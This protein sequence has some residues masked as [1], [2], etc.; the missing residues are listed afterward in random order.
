MSANE[1]SITAAIGASGS[2][3]SAWIKEGLRRAAPTR[4]LVWDPQGEYSTFGRAYTDRVRLLDAVVKAPAFAAV[5][6]PGDRQSLYAERFDWFCRLA[7]AL[8]DLALVV[9]ELADVTQPSRAPDGWSVVT[10]K[11]RHKALRVVAASQRPASVDKDFFGN[12]TLIHCGRLNYEADLRTMANV[13]RVEAPELAGLEPL[14]WVERNML[15][16]ELR[17]GALALGKA[18][19][20][21]RRRA[22][23]DRVTTSS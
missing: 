15:T 4:L 18:P 22:R 17:R 13:L 11:G 19:G 2:G 12:C 14:A 10:R 20:G 8:G 23:A 21:A 1:A 7:Y 16:G 5:Y 3:K 6:Q 9:E